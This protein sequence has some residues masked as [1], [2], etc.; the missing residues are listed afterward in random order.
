MRI[1]LVLFC[2]FSILSTKAQDSILVKT[3][4]VLE[5]YKCFCPKKKEGKLIRTMQEAKTDLEVGYYINP[6]KCSCL[7]MDSL[8][9]DFVKYDIVFLNLFGGSHNP[10]QVETFLYS[11]P[12]SKKNI[13]I[14]KIK[15]DKDWNLKVGIFVPIRILIP[16]LD[17]NYSFEYKVEEVEATK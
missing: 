11:L 15:K 6:H 10:P 12:G 17:A 7:S 5:K 1:I 2:L 9:I 14:I 8:Q 16:K 3:E 13:L 4:N